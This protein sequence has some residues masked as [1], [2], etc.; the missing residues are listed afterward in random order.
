MQIEDEIEQL[1]KSLDVSDELHPN[2][3][4]LEIRKLKHRVLTSHDRLERALETRILM[5][6]VSTDSDN[7]TNAINNAIIFS[8]LEKL[9]D[10]LSFNSKVSIVCEYPDIPKT[11]NLNVDIFK[12]SIGKVNKYRN[13]FVHWEGLRLNRMYNKNDSSTKIMVRDLLRALVRAE[14]MMSVYFTVIKK[15]NEI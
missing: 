13:Q 1:E 10:N 8:K 11:K 6:F 3:L 15:N 9:I 7:E 4:H 14:K 2:Y 5:E 12:E